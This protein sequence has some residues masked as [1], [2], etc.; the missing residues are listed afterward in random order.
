MQMRQ[1]C[2]CAWLFLEVVHVVGGNQFQAKLLR[3]GNQM[4]VDLGLFG[5]AVVLQFEVEVI[6][7]ESLLEPINRLARLGQLVLLN[8]LRDF[9]RQAARER[10]EPVLVRGQQFFVNAGLVVIAL[11]MGGG[12]ELDEILVA[13][14]ILGQEEQVVI[15]VPRSRSSLLLEAAAGRNIDLAADDRLDASLAAPPGRS[16]SRHRARRDR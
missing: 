13:G 9:A 11:Q 4:P 12:R 3:P 6:R 1:S 10:D 16:Q 15:N 5:Q 14:L 8:Q 7:P 2:A